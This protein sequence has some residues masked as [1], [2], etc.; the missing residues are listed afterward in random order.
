M[1]LCEKCLRPFSDD[2]T[3]NINYRSI[4]KYTFLFCLLVCSVS[5]LQVLKALFYADSRKL[6]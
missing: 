4:F 6:G 5:E 2:V 1:M 3:Q